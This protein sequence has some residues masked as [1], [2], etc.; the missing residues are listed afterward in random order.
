VIYYLCVFM[1]KY[2]YSHH[3]GLFLL[4][5]VLATVFMFHFLPKLAATEQMVAFIWGAPHMLGLDFLPVSVWF[6]LALVGELFIVISALL[7]ILTRLWSVV[8]FIVMIFAMIAKKWWFPA[9][10]VDLILMW[11]WIVLFV[12]WPWKYSLSKHHRVWHDHAKVVGSV[13]KET[14]P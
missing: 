9:I 4:R 2:S 1:K 8:L 12:A 14:T 5:L 10:E 13:V 3:T 7:G 11:I 6:Y